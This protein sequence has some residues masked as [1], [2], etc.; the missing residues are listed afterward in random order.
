MVVPIETDPTFRQGTPQVLFNLTPYFTPGGG[1]GTY[2]DVAPDGERFLL[3][4]RGATS[5]TEDPL[6]QPQIIVVRNWF[7]ELQRLVPV[8]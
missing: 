2:W 1:A 7:E 8:P 3:I 5:T 4:K 6:A